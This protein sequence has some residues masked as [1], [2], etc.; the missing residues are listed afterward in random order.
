MS[1]PD[2]SE[3]KLFLLTRPLRPSTLRAYKSALLI[4]LTWCRDRGEVPKLRHPPSLDKLLLEWFHEVYLDKD[5]AGREGCSKALCALVHFRPYLAG[6]LTLSLR[7][8][9]NWRRLRPPVSYPPLTWS[10]TVAVALRVAT[11]AGALPA[12]AIL[13]AFDGFLRANELLSLTTD[14]V[15]DPAGGDSRALGVGVLPN[16]VIVL[17]VAKTGRNQSVVMQNPQVQDFLRFV[18]KISKRGERLFPFSRE[19]LLSVFKKACRAY[20]LKDPYV[21]HSLRHGAA[22]NAIM[23]GASLD[24]VLVR[25]RWAATKSAIRYIQTGRALL[26]TL[27]SPA[28]VVSYGTLASS[29]IAPFLEWACEQ[30]L[31]ALRR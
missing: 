14:D 13:V 30:F 2:L 15:L 5:G 21:L 3:S 1:V 9:S 8:L 24:S 31:I 6:T 16:M 19:W 4:F 12:I 22:T 28:D 20:G 11:Y 18:L 23:C 7:A 27:S 25:G 10:L 26:S 29:D 17:K